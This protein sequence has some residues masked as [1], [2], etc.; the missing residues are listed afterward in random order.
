MKQKTTGI[1]FQTCFT[2]KYAYKFFFGKPH[3][4]RPFTKCSSWVVSIPGP[5]LGR[6]WSLVT[7][8][9]VSGG[10]P[11]SLHA[12][13]TVKSYLAITTSF[14]FHY[15][16]SI[17]S[18]HAIYSHFFRNKQLYHLRFIMK[19]ERPVSKCDCTMILACAVT[20]PGSLHRP[21]CAATLLP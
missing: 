6:L 15:S 18:T 12:N 17:L 21:L 9:K 14:P 5:Y 16:P 4:K 8:T 19:Y 10:L 2:A 7:L 11:V 13:K 3:G 1:L 20:Y